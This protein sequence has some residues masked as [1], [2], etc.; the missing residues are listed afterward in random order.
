MLLIRT[1][2]RP[3]RDKSTNLTYLER[4]IIITY[5]PQKITSS[6]LKVYANI[7]LQGMTPR[8]KG[9][10][11]LHEGRSDSKP[12]KATREASTLQGPD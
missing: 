9:S 1:N 6:I 3:V 5:F 2:M 4:P 12:T 11:K 8:S 10:I 7:K